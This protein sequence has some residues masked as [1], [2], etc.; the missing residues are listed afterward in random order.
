MIIHDGWETAEAW[1][2]VCA[3]VRTIR[4]QELSQGNIYV[5]KVWFYI[6]K[7]KEEKRS[8]RWATGMVVSPFLPRHFRCAD[9]G[10]QRRR[11]S[12]AAESMAPS[13]VDAMNRLSV[14]IKWSCPVP[15]CSIAAPLLC[16]PETREQDLLL[17]Q[18]FLW[19]IPRA[20]DLHGLSSGMEPWAILWGWWLFAFYS[21]K[22]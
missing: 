14:V 2:R 18:T 10:S 12:S 22:G 21:K 19:I 3:F 16:G 13:R 11:H 8:L 9:M 6:R 15:V 20:W 1:W 7:K 17:M 5:I 4:E